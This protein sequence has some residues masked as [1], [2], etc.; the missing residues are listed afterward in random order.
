MRTEIGCEL[1]SLLKHLE[2][3]PKDA[4]DFPTTFSG[5]TNLMKKIKDELSDKVYPHIV[6][7]VAARDD[8]LLNDHGVDH[9]NMVEQRAFQ[10]LG[11]KRKLLNGTEI[12][13]LLAAI[14]FHDIGNMYGRDGHEKNI[15][16]VLRNCS[17]FT[18]K[19]LSLLLM[20]AS[21]IASAHGGIIG[22]EKSKDTLSSMVPCDNFANTKIRPAMLAA[23][24]RFADELADDCTRCA[25][26][27][28]NSDD[29]DSKE[30]VASAFKKSEIY[31]I[32][33]QVLQP[34]NINQ[35]R[36]HLEYLIP[37]DYACKRFGKMG[38]NV[39]LYDEILKRLRK[40]FA[41]MIYCSGYSDGL[42]HH[43]SLSATINVHNE[44]GVTLK[45]VDILVNARGYPLCAN[46]SIGELFK[47]QIDE[48]PTGIKLRSY[49]K[50]CSR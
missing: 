18:E 10:L 30:K 41:E 26:S 21:K 4:N 6:S 45:K 34:A 12:M 14:Y 47:G 8:I 27:I 13:L 44:D 43:S 20:Q 48:C 50:G 5:Y 1:E 36:I 9:V 7:A 22:D 3:H 49:L 42:L 28:L 11:D 19:R 37:K 15:M 40:V 35:S 46:A 24:V 39:Y 16:R 33:S 23:I 38:R 31:H 25:D 32:Y 29:M 2:S 17:F